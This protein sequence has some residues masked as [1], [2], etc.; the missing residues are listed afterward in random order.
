MAFDI[1]IID[2]EDDIRSLIEGILQ[3]EGYVTRQAANDVEAYAEITKKTPDLVILDIWLNNSQ[4]DG[5]KILQTFKKEHLDV[6]VVMISGHGNIETAVSAIKLGAYD[7]IE[8]P[9]KTDRLLL[10]MNRALETASLRR[11]NEVLKSKT[12]VHDELVGESSIMVMLRQ[13]L[14]RIA[15]TNGRVLI[16]G[17]AGTGKDI[18]ARFIHKRSS[19]AAM[20]FMILN[21]ATLRPD[22]LETELFGAEDESG[23]VIQGVL[24]RSNGGTLVLDEVADMPFET[25][26]KILR[27][28]QDQ[29]FKRVG[30]NTVIDADVRILATTNR[31]LAA[32]IKQGAF[33]ED[34]FYRLNVVPI[35][36][37]PLNERL[38]DI[39][40]LSNFFASQYTKSSGLPDVSFASQAI[41]VM[42]HYEWP[43][44]VRQ[45]RN[46]VEWCII[47]RGAQAQGKLKPEDLPPEISFKSD[48]DSLGEGKLTAKI[49]E[50]LVNLPLR[51]AREVFEM[52]YLQA[53]ID[54]FDG[55]I[56]KTASFIEMER[57]ALHRK[58]KQLGLLT[59][60]KNQPK[61]QSKN[62]EE[63]ASI[64]KKHKRA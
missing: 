24:E 13:T 56:S 23:N 6:P 38:K 53:Q 10:M 9:F 47:M 1:L 60:S 64:P 49:D 61:N 30:G 52:Q 36:M 22:R 58:I 31:D 29:N 11:E 34:L 33:R 27:A 40:I 25:Q 5:L 26:G 48:D 18:A 37:P 41:S 43:G 7:F 21:C 46:V 3:D 35:E 16:T 50:S 2:D 28:L 17:E 63:L 8:K 15:K 32:Q 57:S 19:R 39:G 59:E 42:Q 44:N 4:D 54:R 51:D 45:L 55:N 62:E 20:P 12:V 14:E